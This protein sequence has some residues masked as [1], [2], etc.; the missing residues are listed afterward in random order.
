MDELFYRYNP[1]WEARY[2]TESFIER[3]ALLEAMRKHLGTGRIVLLTGLRRVGKTTLLKLFVRHLME[4]EG[5]KSGSLFYIS[6]DDYLLSRKTILELVDDFRKVRRLRF[7]EKA[8]LFLDEVAY[9][10]DF[11]V[12][13]K[14]LQDS[15]NL[16]IYASSSSASVL[17]G[18]K[19]W[20]TGRSVILEV[21]PLDFNEYLRFK[22]IKVAR[23][24]SHL[25]EGYF[26]EYL[27]SGGIPEYVL[28]PNIEYLRELVDDI[29]FKD[30][31]A[32]H[33]LRNTR[34]LKE[35]FLLLMERAG[36]TASINKMARIMKI[37]PDTAR[38][39]LDMFA[40]T[41]LIHLVA[42]W[43]KTNERILSPKKVY[44]ADL[45]IRTLFTGFRDKG[46]LFENYVYLKLRGLNPCYVCQEGNEI[47]FLTENNDLLEVK[48][49]GSLGVR[50]RAL[51]ESFKARGKYL[52]LGNGGLEEYL[53]LPS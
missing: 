26:E 31:A 28:R 29:I 18:K 35:F 6:L 34:I 44:A 47:D 38:R 49:K 42:R 40:D 45:G 14:N 10:E 23:S 27:N 25:I 39:Y 1:W 2:Q 7:A 12:Q 51:F 9:K 15:Q 17:R 16:Q 37:S 22:G 8:Y 3:P 52:I 24:D 11:E 48:Y 33:N 46:S 36:K 4:E 50:Q 20:L 5:I 53:A 32:F 21:L 41:Y 30:I 13:L 43:G 19:P